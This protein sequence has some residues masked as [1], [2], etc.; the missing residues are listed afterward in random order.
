MDYVEVP[1]HFVAVKLHVGTTTR[2]CPSCACVFMSAVHELSPVSKKL[3]FTAS[4]TLAENSV[5]S[6][7]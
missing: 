6:Q 5:F 1:Q 7:L 4:V 2:P 3:L